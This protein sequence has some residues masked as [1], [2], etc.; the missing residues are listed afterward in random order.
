MPSPG[1]GSWCKKDAEQCGLQKA[2][3]LSCESAKTGYMAKL[4]PGHHLIPLTNYCLHCNP[5]L[6]YLFSFA[7]R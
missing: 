6:H 5:L 1:C 2:T 3:R 7:V 4:D